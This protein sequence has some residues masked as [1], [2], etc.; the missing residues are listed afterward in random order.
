LF[1]FLP[2]VNFIVH[3]LKISELGTLVIFIQMFDELV[4][5]F[6]VKIS[7]PIINVVNNK[8]ITFLKKFM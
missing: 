4:I 2:Y 7:V 1:R 8:N 5:Y 6:I 3:I